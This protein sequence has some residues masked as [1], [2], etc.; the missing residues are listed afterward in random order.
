MIMPLASLGFPHSRKKWLE[1]RTVAV[2]KGT[3]PGTK[4]E[5]HKQS[6][7]FNFIE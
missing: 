7:K 5:N 3:G 4:R 2:K 6:R 1:P